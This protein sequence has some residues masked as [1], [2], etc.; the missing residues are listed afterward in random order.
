MD[1]FVYFQL[2]VEE[3]FNIGMDLFKVIEKSDIVFYVFE[4][5]Q[6][7]LYNEVMEKI[8]KI[9][10]YGKGDVEEVLKV[11][12]FFVIKDVYFIV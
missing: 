9:M 10:G 1:F 7:R 4:V 8:S 11:E 12:E 6:E 3:F 5:V 2:L